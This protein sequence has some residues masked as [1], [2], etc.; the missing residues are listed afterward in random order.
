M[1][2]QRHH[3]KCDSRNV[4]NMTTTED[5]INFDVIEDSKENI[6][7]LP[8]G[9]SAK[10]LASVFSPVAIKSPAITQDINDAARQEFEKELETIDDS[11]DPLDIYD[12]YCKWTLDAY[13]TAQ[14]TPQSQLL[15]LLERATKAFLSSP[16]YKDDPRYLKVWLNYIRFFSDA[17][18][19]TFAYLSRH[20]VGE[21]LA[22]YYEEFAAWLE[23]A[24]RW[25]QAEEVYKMGIER[26]ARPAERLT[27][28]FGEFEKRLE[29]QPKEA[30][31]PASPALPT[32]RPALVAKIDPFLSRSPEWRNAQTQQ[33]SRRPAPTNTGGKKLEIFS[34]DSSESKAVYGGTSK[35]WENIGSLAERRKE[36][37]TSAT[38]WTGETMKSAKVPSMVPKMM[39]FKDPVSVPAHSLIPKPYIYNYRTNGGLACIS[40]YVPCSNATSCKSPIS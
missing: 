37:A 8:S 13:P 28:K 34:D 4:L 24:G 30:K 11:D 12:R 2:S 36:N 6:Q 29:A 1:A 22:L 15:P 40:V 7:A 39:V 38:P 18:R 21:G 27:R 19:E 16:H 23:S 3:R 17:P 5:L 35:G 31:E 14:A 9:R 20:G 25:S 33:P 10:A 32:M 26:D